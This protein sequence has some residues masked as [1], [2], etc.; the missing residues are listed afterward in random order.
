[1]TFMYDFRAMDRDRL[2]AGL[3]GSD[4]AKKAGLSVPHV[5]QFFKGYG[6]VSPGAAKRIAKALGRPLSAYI[7][8]SEG[9]DSHV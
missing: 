5:T 2:A 6:N 8:S 7:V 1:M 4:V 3:S 9:S